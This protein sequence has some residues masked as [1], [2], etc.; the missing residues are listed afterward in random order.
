MK[1]REIMK[2]LLQLDK[3]KKNKKAVSEIV[4]YTLLI[5]IAIGVSSLVYYFLQLQTPKEKTECKDGIS[6]GIDYV[7]CE[8]KPNQDR[9][10]TLTLL[11]NGRFKVDA[12]YVRVG[13]EGQ[14]QSVRYWINDP[15]KDADGVPIPEA[16]LKSGAQKTRDDMF[17][18]SSTSSSAN[19]GLAPG[20]ISIAREHKIFGEVP[21]ST[22]YI[23]E[24]EPAIL[25]EQTG[26]LAA[27]ENA[28]IA[29]KITCPA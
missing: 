9:N 3:K 1:R 8:I 23:L 11:N 10:L 15:E 14:G 4:S 19:T 29:Q 17:Y 5:V 7:K 12:A 21:S 22:N 26:R 20:L 2:D 16:D 13:V 6:L 27:C 18:L 25:S 28:V 24:I